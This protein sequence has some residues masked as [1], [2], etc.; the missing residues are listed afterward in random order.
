MTLRFDAWWECQPGRL[1]FAW[2]ARV[3]WGRV[4]QSTFHSWITWAFLPTPLNPSWITW[5][6]SPTPLDLSWT[7]WAFLPTPLGPSWITWASP[8]A[9][10]VW[11]SAR[12]SPRLAVAYIS[13]S[14]LSNYPSVIHSPLV[15]PADVALSR[16]TRH[17][18]LSG[19]F[20]C[21]RCNLLPLCDIQLCDLVFLD[22]WA[23]YFE[24]TTAPRSIEMPT[25]PRNNRHLASFWIHFSWFRPRILAIF[26]TR[27]ERSISIIVLRIIH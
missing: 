26:A 25:L 19:P 17:G 27:Y 3:T 1:F 23:P 8:S 2:I 12:R 21:Y 22:R 4:S 14:V 15:R 11:D 10:L 20:R 13:T 7:T 5:A 9:S 6:L 24:D 18:Y 16:F